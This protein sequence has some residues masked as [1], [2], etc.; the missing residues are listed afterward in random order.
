MTIEELQILKGKVKKGNILLGRISA[1]NKKI[2]AFTRLES[3]P[4]VHEHVKIY[5]SKM[6]II[7]VDNKKLLREEFDKL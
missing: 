3:N 2:I 6:I 4:N 1:A 5:A 7:W